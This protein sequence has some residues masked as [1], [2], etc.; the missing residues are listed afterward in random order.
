MQ[1]SIIYRIY[2]SRGEE[3]KTMQIFHS[4]TQ[5]L[6]RLWYETRLQIFS[7]EIYFSFA[8][9]NVAAGRI[10]V[11][12]ISVV[13][14]IHTQSA[15]VSVS[16]YIQDIRRMKQDTAC[17][18]SCPSSKFAETTFQRGWQWSRPTFRSVERARVNFPRTLAVRRI[19]SSRDAT[20]CGCRVV[21]A[22][23]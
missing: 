18:S 19:I 4:E 17:A 10:M 6:S 7:T 8:S 13:I 16:M 21:K 20:W 14:I 9:I 23:K 15:F 1:L 12:C 11:S 3:W 22:A 5:K 2:F